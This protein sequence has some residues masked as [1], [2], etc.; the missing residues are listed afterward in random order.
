LPSETVVICRDAAPR[1][2]TA[3]ISG[4]RA[5]SDQPHI[6]SHPHD[7]AFFSGRHAIEVLHQHH[8]FAYLHLTL[9]PEAKQPINRPRIVGAPL[10]PLV[11]LS[12]VEEP[13]NKTSN[14][15]GDKEYVSKWLPQI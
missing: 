14:R 8:G 2:V 6:A 12:A 4:R 9:A 15:R 5:A 1:A 11:F 3:S 7:P 10:C 13:Q